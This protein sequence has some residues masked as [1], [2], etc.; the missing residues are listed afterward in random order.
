MEVE[1][2]LTTADVIDIL[3][4]V[5]LIRDVP[6]FIRSDSGPEF[7]APAIRRYLET[8]GAGP[9]YMAPGNP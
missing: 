3:A 7:I 8:T 2:S 5:F 1:R 6:R 9:L 4:Q